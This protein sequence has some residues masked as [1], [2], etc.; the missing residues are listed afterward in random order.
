M[1]FLAKLSQLK[2]P[3]TERNTKKVEKNISNELSVDPLRSESNLLPKNYVREEDPAVRRLKE[4]RRQ[5]QLKKGAN[6]PKPP[7]P[8]NKR[9][10]RDDEPMATEA[11]FKR[12]IGANDKKPVTPLTR[13]EPLKKLSFEELMKEAEEKAK[14]KSASPESFAPNHKNARKPPLQ[15]PGFKSGKSKVRTQANQTPPSI[16]KET[17]PKI[18]VPLAKAALAQP[19]EKLRKKLDLIKKSRRDQGYEDDGNLDDFIDDDEEE[20]DYDRDEIWAMFNKGRK[21]A[22]Y[23]YSDDESDMEANELEI[24]EEEEKASRMARLEDKREQQWLKKHEEEKR[25]RMN[26]K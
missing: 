1:S 12:K 22:E 8:S 3:V 4:L 16:K 6:K 15:K 17:K 11:K 7:A 18:K 10:R 21:R 2:K 13:R 24:F 20:L 14:N 19:S 9:R 5:E 26:R 23:Q 25:R